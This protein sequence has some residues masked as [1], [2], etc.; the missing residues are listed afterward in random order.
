VQLYK[1]NL[2]VILKS[3][4]FYQNSYEIIH[5]VIST[6]LVDAGFEKFHN[7]KTVKCF[8]VSNFFNPKNK[9]YQTGKNNFLLYT[10][11]IEVAKIINS[12]AFLYEDNILKVNEVVVKQIDIK[13]I[14][15]LI[16]K[17]PV[18]I[19]LKEKNRYW[20]LNKSGDIQLLQEAIVN[21]LVRKYEIFF[22]EKLQLQY[23]PI[24]FLKINP[25]VEK[26]ILNS[27]KATLYGHKLEIGFN[28][29]ETSQKLAFLA[30][31]CG[32]GEKNSFG[33]GFCEVRDDL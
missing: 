27:K 31:S 15:K 29:D 19:T 18:I 26:I 25:I 8:V 23:S 12:E 3:K 33:G 32:V 4:I 1:L 24:N 28:D 6:I 7:N 30:F 17:N 5:K 20:T 21:N 16:S 10:S 2:K 14:Q 22:N 13:F 9:Y 11:N